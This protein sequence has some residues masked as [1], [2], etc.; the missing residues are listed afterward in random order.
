MATNPSGQGLLSM[1][2]ASRILPMG[3]CDPDRQHSRQADWPAK[4]IEEAVSMLTG[5]RAFENL[6]QADP[7]AD[8]PF[9]RCIGSNL[10]YKNLITSAQTIATRWNWLMRQYGQAR[11]HA[12]TFSERCT[13]TGCADFVSKV[14]VSGRTRRVCGPC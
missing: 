8:R 12:A 7:P 6:K 14:L 9:L 11:S 4:A 1:T 3:N 5:N 2:S 13:T 10:W